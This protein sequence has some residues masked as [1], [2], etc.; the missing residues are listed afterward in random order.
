MPSARATTWPAIQ[1]ALQP[2]WISCHTGLGV[3][4][5]KA[6]PA[7]GWGLGASQ[8]CGRPPAEAGAS[9]SGTTI[10]SR[11]RLIRFDH[12]QLPAPN[13]ERPSKAGLKRRR[14][15]VDHRRARQPSRC[16][17]SAPAVVPVPGLGPEP[18]PT[19]AGGAHAARTFSSP[20]FQAEV[21]E[22]APASTQASR[23][24]RR[25][26]DFEQSATFRR[27]RRRAGAQQTKL[28]PRS[29]PA[30]PLTGVS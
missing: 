19:P 13:D 11:S 18:P 20:W 1:A 5:A 26:G 27:R 6:G 16:G 10:R 7:R 2:R 14:G 3:A 9:G 29:R 22:L 12:G 25:S 30:S 15:I 23:R 28:L 21:A 17:A 8:R 24:R 4:A